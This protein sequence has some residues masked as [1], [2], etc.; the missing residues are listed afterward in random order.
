MSASEHEKTRWYTQF[1]AWFVIGILVFAVVL[2]LGMLTFATMNPDVPVVANYY[3]VGKG[4]NASLEREKLAKKLNLSATLTLDD[5]T[6]TANL[7]LVGFSNPQ[8]LE[9]NLISPTQAEKDRRVI[10]QPR[11][12]GSYQGFMLDSVSGRRFVE[13]LGQ[14]GGKPWRLYVEKEVIPGQPLTLEN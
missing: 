6:G 2:G 8:Q 1:W 5:E 13:L 7:Q 3:D 9:L 11:D 12:D 10:L 4:I 14:E